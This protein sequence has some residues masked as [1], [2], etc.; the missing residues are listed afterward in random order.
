[1]THLDAKKTPSFGIG[2]R[3]NKLASTLIE[4]P[5]PTAYT[6]KSEFEL[7]RTSRQFLNNGKGF[8]FSE[9]FSKY[10]KVYHEC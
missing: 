1:M 4:K 7:N 9:P 2:E 10:E 6:L 3:F 8:S 5:G